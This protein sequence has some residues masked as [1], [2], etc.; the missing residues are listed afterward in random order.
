MDSH[1]TG[2][3]DFIWVG[4]TDEEKIEGDGRH[5][6][7]YEPALEIVDGDFTRMTDDLVVLVDVRRTKVYDDV[8]EEHDVDEKVDDGEWVVVT[9]QDAAVFELPLLLHV[10]VVVQK[11]GSDVRRADGRVD[12]EDENDPVPDGFEGGVMDDRE[13]VLRRSLQLVLGKYFGTQREHLQKSQF[14][15]LSRISTWLYTGMHTYI[16]TGCLYKK[17]WITSHISG[18]C[19][20]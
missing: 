14:K 13:P 6:V 16:C 2:V 19:S 5:D 12:D 9:L 7:D 20:S 8:D 18:E 15:C 17:L 3:V 1:F 4:P 11:K 10:L